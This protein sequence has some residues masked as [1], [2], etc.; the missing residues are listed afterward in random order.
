MTRFSNVVLPTY[1]KVL[2]GPAFTSHSGS[3]TL[4][5]SLS[6]ILS[7]SLLT[8]MAGHSISIPTPP[9]RVAPDVPSLALCHTL[10]FSHLTLW[11][12]T[13]HTSFI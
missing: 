11:H 6:L 5:L 12:L 2:A 10:H 9:L 1:L 8:F 13:L 4:S 7:L 3:C